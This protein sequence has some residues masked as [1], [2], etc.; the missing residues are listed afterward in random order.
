MKFTLKHLLMGIAWLVVSMN[1]SASIDVVT[2][3]GVGCDSEDGTC[4]AIL[5]ESLAGSN[6]THKKQL[7][8]NP[9]S[10]GS[11]GQYSALLTAF[12]GGKRIRVKTEA[13]FQDH[14]TP[15]WLYITD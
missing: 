10:K 9:D 13:C 12:M 6:C 5:R 3:I 15:D 1:V 7:R 4:F 8:L 11:K 2:P 14:P